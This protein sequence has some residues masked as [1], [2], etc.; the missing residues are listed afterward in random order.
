[1]GIPASHDSGG[2]ILSWPS[3]CGAATG[4]RARAV[5]RFGARGACAP[6]FFVREAGFGP[7]LDTVT[8]GS[9]CSFAACPGCGAV[10]AAPGPAE[11]NATATNVDVES[12]REWSA[13]RRPVQAMLHR[14]A[15]TLGNM[16]TPR[17][18][19]PVARHRELGVPLIRQG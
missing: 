9:C 17:V 1:M 7:P 19:R 13:I 14:A 15:A 4:V 2:A 6:E 8:G 16:E 18:T 12:R 3:C 5:D 11:S 10:W